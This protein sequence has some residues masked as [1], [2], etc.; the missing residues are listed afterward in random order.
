MKVAVIGGGGRVGSCTAYALQWAGVV[1]EIFLYDVLSQAAQGEALDLM[2]GSPLLHDQRFLSVNIKQCAQAD[3]VIITAGMRRKPGE[4]RRDLLSRNAALFRAILASLREENWRRDAF[5]VVVSNPVDVLTALAV[6]ESGLPLERIVG[7]GT[8]LDSSRFSA[9]IAA[10]LGV[11]P[12][13]VKAWVLG[14]HGD[15]MVPVWSSVNYAGFPLGKNLKLTVVEMTRIEEET[16]RSGAE[17]I[18]LKGG[19]GW[20]VATSIAHVVHTIVLDQ[21]RILPVSTWQNGAYDLYDVC[22]SVPTVLGKKGVMGHVE[23]DLWARELQALKRSGDAVK[24][25]LG[26]LEELV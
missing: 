16:K 21:K 13:Q 1:S 20:A 22:L 11:A 26:E 6:K 23:C 5:L 10:S 24:R 2:H 17:L 18:R 9:L 8:L 15:S 12:S 3:M 14:E 25:T 4:S 19:A 7:L